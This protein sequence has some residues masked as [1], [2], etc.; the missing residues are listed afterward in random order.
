MV[1]WALGMNRWRCAKCG[2]RMRSR[3]I[4]VLDNRIKAHL[5][6]HLQEGKNKHGQ[7]DIQICI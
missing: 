7:K 5:E 1:R 3:N 2:K 4:D 6:Q